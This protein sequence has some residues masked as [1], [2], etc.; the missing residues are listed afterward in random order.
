MPRITHATI[1]TTI[2][3]EVT[4]TYGAAFTLMTAEAIQVDWTDSQGRREQIDQAI[5]EHAAHFF[6]KIPGAMS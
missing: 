5:N 6:D 1:R 2:T 4:P 3:V